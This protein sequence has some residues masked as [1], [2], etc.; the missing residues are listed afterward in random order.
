MGE[1]G[2]KRWRGKGN[3]G[4]RKGGRIGPQKETPGSRDGQCDSQLFQGFY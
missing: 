1:R 3:R 2:F 4:R